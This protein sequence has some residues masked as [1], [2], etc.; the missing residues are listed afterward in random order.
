MMQGL[1]VGGQTLYSVFPILVVAFLVAGLVTILI[2][3]TLVSKWL[4]KDAGWKGPFLGS[5]LGAMVPGGPFFFY[6]LMSTLIVSGANVDTMISFV[7]AKT[8]WN[9]GRLP[10]EV[11]FVG[12]RITIIRFVITFFIPVLAGTAVDF[13]LPGYAEKIRLEVKQLQEKNAVQRRGA[14]GD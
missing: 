3:K 14:R 4:G 9:I 2:P 10:V 11:A 5:V 13:F 7:A 6:P 12:W 1:I 8:L